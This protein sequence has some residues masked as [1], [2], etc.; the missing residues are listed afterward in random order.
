MYGQH[1]TRNGRSLAGC[2]ALAALVLGIA[3]CAGTSS[4][5]SSSGGEITVGSV[6]DQTGPLDIYGKGMTIATKMAVDDI[7]SSGG[8]NGK[9]LKLVAYDTQSDNAKYTQYT[10]QLINQNNAVVVMGGI[11]SASREAVRPVTD[12]AKIP[13]FYNEQYEGGVCDH[14]NFLTGGVPSQQLATLMPYSIKKYGK[15]IFVVAA[16]YNYGQISAQWVDKL[17]KES[18]AQVVKTDFVPLASSD[19]GSVLNDIQSSKPDMVVSLLVG[20]NHIPFYKQYA[21]LGLKSTIPI[22][23]STFGQGAEESILTPAEA[24][25]ILVAY[26]YFRAIDTPQNKK[27]IQK[28]DQANPNVPLADSAISVWNGWH[29]WA[30]A[31]NKAKSTDQAKVIKALEAGTTYESLNGKITMDGKSHHLT[32][33]ISLAQVNDKQSYDIIETKQQVV[34][35]F[36]QSV[37]NLIKDP[38][39]NKQFTP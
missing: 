24:Q 6:L 5:Q 30:I 33:N 31:A 38:S 16:D 3:G 11:T 36:E 28:W 25:G 14:D 39:Q 27:F 18:G 9:K 15:K 17:A 22:V 7:N 32:Q 23:S 26:P 13:Y 35:S 1:G 2:A 21:S 10:N 29:L 19:F 37:C 34:P 8:V 4:T 20:A 12:K